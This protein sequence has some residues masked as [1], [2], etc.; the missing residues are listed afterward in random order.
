[1]MSAIVFLAGCPPAQNPSGGNAGGGSGGTGIG[2]EQLKGVWELVIAANQ[3][4]TNIFLYFDGTKMYSA[5]KA[6]EQFISVP[7]GTPFLEYKDGKL[8]YGIAGTMV[9]FIGKKNGENIDLYAKAN[10]QVSPTPVYTLK[11]STESAEAIKEAGS[12]EPCTGRC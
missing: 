2:K 5:V 3:Q 12:D 6:G 9:E 11:P 10:G 7:A 8:Q 4:T 1:M